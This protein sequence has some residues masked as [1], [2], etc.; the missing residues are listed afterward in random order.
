MQPKA[1]TLLVKN[2]KRVPL[3]QKVV[4][5]I[6]RG[7]DSAT[8]NSFQNQPSNSVML[9]AQWH[10]GPV[11]RNKRGSGIEISQN[12]ERLVSITNSHRQKSAEPNKQKLEWKDS[13][14]VFSTKTRSSG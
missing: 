5:S 11:L 1:P 13:Q 14:H 2:E 4:L 3:D 10:M 6:N 7:S 9:K 12:H 8:V